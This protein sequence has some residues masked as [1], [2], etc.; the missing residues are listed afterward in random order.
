MSKGN[1]FS[2]IFLVPI[3]TGVLDIAIF[4]LSLM[5]LNFIDYIIEASRC[6]KEKYYLF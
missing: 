5:G 3:E 1:Y 4:C 2:N 6:L